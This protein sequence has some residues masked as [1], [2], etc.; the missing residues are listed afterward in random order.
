MMKGRVNIMISGAQ[1][2]YFVPTKIMFGRGQVKNLHNCILPGKKALIVITSGKSTRDNGYLDIVEQE[3]SIAKVGYVVYDKV[4]SN[5]V[6]K[7]IVEGAKMAREHQCDFILG[8]GGGSPIDA[9]KAIALLATNEGE[10]WDY[11]G[12]GSGKGLPVKNRPLPV[13]AITTT[14]G[15]GS[16]AD[17]AF[18]VSKEETNEKIGL[19][20]PDLFPTIAVVDPD[21]MTTVP[22][23]YTAFQ[24]FDALFHSTE[25]YISNKANLMSDMVALT[26]IELIGQNLAVAVRNGSDINAREKVALGSTLS[27]IQMAVGSLTSKHSLEHAMSAYHQNLPHGAGLVLISIAYYKRFVNAPEL[28]ERF[29]KMAKAMGMEAAT[30][31]MDFIVALE[32]LIEDCS[33]SDLKMSEYEVTKEELGTF[34]KNAKFTMGSK[35]YNDYVVLSEEDCVQIYL[36]SYK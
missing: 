18:V 3:L 1:F 12:A 8:L 35:F 25:G 26:A 15:T 19:Y 29:I 14:A 10:L 20:L 5:P 4:A 11:I 6:V 22:P 32:E 2:Q 24:G 17:P 34:A 36:E 28:R 7:N 33:L 23:L 9:S 21:L 31:P 16:E 30:E 27:G 13:V